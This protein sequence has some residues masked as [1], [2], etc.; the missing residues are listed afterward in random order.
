[1]NDRE[2]TPPEDTLH[3]GREIECFR[4][5]W[6][7]VVS[8]VLAGPVLLLVSGGLV[9]A[10][11]LARWPRTEPGWPITVLAIVGMT[12]GLRGLYALALLAWLQLSVHEGGFVLRS[13]AGTHAA[14]WEAVREIRTLRG[15]WGD[16]AL[17]VELVH[18][19][20]V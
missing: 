17:G 19:G 4:A 5:S 20:M 7:A 15:R 11:W 9:L 2:T 13:G 6:K 18:G 14:S 12:L 8:R 3:L 1:M 16:V 10:Q